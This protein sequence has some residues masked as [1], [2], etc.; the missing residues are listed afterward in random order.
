MNIRDYHKGFEVFIVNSTDEAVIKEQN[1]FNKLVPEIHA[2]RERE[3]IKYAMSELNIT[4]RKA[5]AY[6]KG[7]AGLNGKR[8]GI[9]ERLFA[10]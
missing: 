1:D 9:I 2:M 4:E 7:Y 8:K 6:Y 5:T 10:S 3:A